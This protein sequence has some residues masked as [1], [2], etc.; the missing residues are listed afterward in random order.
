[1]GAND[2]FLLDA[3]SDTVSGVVERAGPSVASVKV[4]GAGRD[5][6][7]GGG[8]GFV[9][10]PDGYLLTNSHVV[11]AGEHGGA[12]KRCLAS[13]SDGREFDAHWVGDDPDTDLAL[14]RIDGMSRGSLAPLVLGRSALLRRGQIAIAIGNPLGFEHTVTAGIVSALGRS[15]RS[16]SGRLI[17]DVIQ[18]D[19]ALNPGNSGG[20]LLDS[21]GEVIGV[22]TAIIRGAQSISFAVAIDI[23]AWVIPQLLQ[24]G[25][26]RRGHLGVGGMTMA[27]D[28]RVVLAFGLTQ[29]HAVRVSAVEP[30]S[31]AARAGLHAGDLIVGLDGVVIDSVDR[32]H[33]TLD[34]SRVHKD[35]VLK[36]LRGNGA[37]QPIYLNVRPAEHPVATAS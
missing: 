19:A 29:A 33:Q 36:L 25:R 8:S 27:L 26:V 9:F 37:S 11:R 6:P 1:M 13:L 31:P 17:P 10:T 15:M 5:A 20:P 35:C 24:H 18:T 21:R 22:N 3:Y 14:L 28:R 30:D 34:A 12:P 23:A 4:H 32:L 16:G 7:L 2:A